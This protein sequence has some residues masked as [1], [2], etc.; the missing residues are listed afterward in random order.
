MGPEGNPL[1]SQNGEQ[2]PSP[3]QPCCPQVSQRTPCKVTG[4]GSTSSFTG[5]GPGGVEDGKN[6][7]PRLWPRRAGAAGRVLAPDLP[8]PSLPQPQELLPQSLGHALLQ[9]A[10]PDPPAARGTCALQWPP[11]GLQPSLSLRWGW[12]GWGWGGRVAGGSAEGGASWLLGRGAPRSFN[13]LPLQGPPNFLRASALA[14]HIKPVV[15]IPEEAPEDEEPEN[16][17]EISTGPPAGEPVVSGAPSLPPPLVPWGSR[18]ELTEQALLPVAGG[19]G[20]LR[21]DLWTPQ[22]LREG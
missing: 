4:T 12:R 11:P 19:G 6:G 9:A 16:L 7:T 17:I 21:T 14:E 22:R 20:P 5:T 15:V 3:L 2:R 18:A 13:P 10:D 1:K 8:P